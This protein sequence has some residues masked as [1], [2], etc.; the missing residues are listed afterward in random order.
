MP[1]GGQE[2][3]GQMMRNAARR[4][5]DAP[6]EPG[7]DVLEQATALAVRRVREFSDAIGRLSR[8]LAEGNLAEGPA[9]A[10]I[11]MELPFAGIAAGKLTAVLEEAMAA[12]E[13]RAVDAAIRAAD[14]AAGVA[15]GEARERARAAS[16]PRQRRAAPGRQH[17]LMLVVGGS[18]AAAA[19]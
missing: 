14:F 15:H 18:A 2:E 1:L 8:H 16:V 6:P 10:V 3:G 17:P 7:P 13:G 5:A 4:E 12:M 9:L 11:A 19:D